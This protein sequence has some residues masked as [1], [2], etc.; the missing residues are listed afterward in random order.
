MQ[1]QEDLVG[2]FRGKSLVG[3]RLLEYMKNGGVIEVRLLKNE[4]LSHMVIGEIPQVFGRKR[5]LVDRL[6]LRMCLLNDM[7]LD[8]PHGVSPS[9]ASPF[10]KIRSMTSRFRFARRCPYSLAHIDYTMLERAE[11]T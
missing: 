9:T 4:R 11:S 5:Q 3:I 8:S 10:A 6:K 7:L 1:L 2:D